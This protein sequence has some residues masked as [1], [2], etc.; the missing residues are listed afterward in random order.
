[1]IALW[2]VRTVVRINGARDHVAKCL[3]MSTVGN[4]DSR[5]SGRKFISEAFLFE[6]VIVLQDSVSDGPVFFAEN[7]SSAHTK[8]IHHLGEGSQ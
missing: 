3:A 2:G 1:M 5:R 4:P 7:G 8:T 6:D